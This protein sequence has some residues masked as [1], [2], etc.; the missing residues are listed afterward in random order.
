[1]PMTS[2]LWQDANADM[3]MF[4]RSDRL[5]IDL[6]AWNRFQFRRSAHRFMLRRK[7]TD[8]EKV[9]DCLLGR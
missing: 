5:E 3:L 4:V 9:V 2:F 7:D 1:M 8:G 6:V